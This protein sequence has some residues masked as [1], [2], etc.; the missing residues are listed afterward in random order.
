MTNG[1]ADTITAAGNGLTIV[2]GFGDDVVNASGIAALIFAN[3]GSDT[4]TAGD[5]AD[6]IFAGIGDDSI[7]AGDGADTLFGNEDN[8]T[9]VG[10]RGDDAASLGEGNDLF[11]WNPG[12]GSDT[13]E[14]DAGDDVLDFNGA[15]VNEVVSISADGTRTHF[16]RDVA[17]I[18]M[19]LNQVERISFDAL[20]GSDD[21]TV[22]DLTGTGVTQVDIDLGGRGGG[23]GEADRVTVNATGRRRRESRR[24]RRRGQ[25][26][27]SCGRHRLIPRRRRRGRP[28][29]QRARRRRHDQRER[30]RERCFGLVFNGGTGADLLVGS[31]GDELL[32]GGDENDTKALL[33]AGDD[34]FVWNP[35]DGNDL[36]EGRAGTADTLLF[37]GANVAENID[38][39]ANGGRVRFVR[40]VANV[41][42]DL[43]DVERIDFQALGGADTIVVDDLSGTDVTEVNIDLSAAGGGG[44]GAADT[45]IINATARRRRGAWSPVPTA[46]PWCWA[47]PRKS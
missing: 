8:D 3:Q 29:A 35:G 11:V 37:N 18:T 25:R 2:G 33:G 47:C 26:R 17:N 39:S 40:D 45:M 5:G 9:I 15:N 31:Q 23:D 42:M 10:G 36:V 20:G 13:V 21:I 46:R 14:G 34:V 6:T 30:G 32:D 43:D 41:T 24:V 27:R 28:H 7:R 16:L 4:V 19:D 22:N 1:G 44:D 12:E 38:I